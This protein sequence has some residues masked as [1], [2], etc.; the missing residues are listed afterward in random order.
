MSF[1]RP[2]YDVFN[3][4]FSAGYLDSPQNDQLPLSATPDAR[5][6]M[7]I[8]AQVGQSTALSIGSR[9]ASMRRRKGARLI[10][11]S[12]MAS[13]TPVESLLNYERDNAAAIMLAVC[14]GGLFS[15][16]GATTYTAIAGAGVGTFTTGRPV[17]ACFHKNLAFLMD[18]DRTKLYDGTTFG[19]PGLSTPIAPGLAVAAGP[20][21][22][23]DYD[24]Y[25]TW[26]NSGRVIESSPGAIAATVTFANQK[27]QWTQPAGAP[28]S[29]THWR[30]YCRKSTERQ[31]YQTGV[32]QLV[33]TA[34]YTESIAD[35]ARTQ[36]GP[37]QSSND[38]PPAFEGMVNWNGYGIAW[39]R[40]ASEV[41]VSKLNF[42]ESWNPN[43]V[44]ALKRNQKVRSVAL[45]GEDVIIQTET[46]TFTLEGDKFPFRLKNLHTQFGNA[47]AQSWQEIDGVVFAFDKKRGP[48]QTDTVN[49]VSIADNKIKTFLSTLNVSEVGNIRSVH[50]QADN[51]VLWSVSVGTYTRRRYILAYNYRLRAWL[52]P[53][54]G[55][56][57]ASFVEFTKS[58]N[59]VALFMGDYWGRVYQFLDTERDGV[60]SGTDHTK[61]ITAATSSVIT[62]GAAAF[63]TTGDGL[64]GIPV[65]ILSPTG[66]WQIRRIQSNTGTVLTLDTIN[67]PVL[68]TVPAAGGTWT[69]VVGL[70]EYYWWT[71][72]MDMN[73]P[74]VQKR[75][76]YL[77]VQGGS[78]NATNG[79]DVALR[80]NG[81]SSVQT[82]KNISF[83][84]TGGV[85]GVSQWGSATW[86][87]G[88]VKKVKRKRIGRAFYAIQIRFSNYYPDQ[89]FEISGYGVG[90]DPLPR[91]RA[92][93]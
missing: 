70:I 34:T 18:G 25:I 9:Q 64:A 42:L 32:D 10:N 69:A 61:P 81:I 17:Q 43:W 55:L 8:N 20:G 36:P 33:A 59:T 58:D 48:Y 35:G 45:V 68:A 40:N 54:N 82:T 1:S 28:A 84:N 7:L 22:T 56:E 67:D 65:G 76:G 50:Y 38:A 16:D 77:L 78:S 83:P 86:G 63:Y 13:A 93:N 51:L 66:A 73:T 44:I 79:L 29:A 37:D 90:A 27:R 23:G 21:V 26:V 92:A 88:A 89:P 49:F 53:M 74:Q 71:P 11:P 15:W 3:R 2:A 46:Q 39:Q 80:F 60:P 14:N 91:R 72:W 41:W 85:W 57:F 4:D 47:S 75:G 6:A 30:V 12:A 31:Y 24:G 62:C 5:N 52:P 19:D 87:G